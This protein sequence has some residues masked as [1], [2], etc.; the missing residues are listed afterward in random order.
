MQYLAGR[1]G[2]KAGAGG[3]NAEEDEAARPRNQF[4]RGSDHGDAAPIEEQVRVRRV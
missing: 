4:A 3:P 2:S 1:A